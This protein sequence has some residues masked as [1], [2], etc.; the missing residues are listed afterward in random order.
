MKAQILLAAFLASFLGGMYMGYHLHSSFT[1]RKEVSIVNDKIEDDNEDK[2]AITE[3]V[4]EVEK[5]VYV[6]RDKIIYLPA[7]TVDDSGCGLN[8]SVGLRQSVY[9]EFPEVL[10]Q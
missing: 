10:F 6:T 8:S 4:T 3:H 5:V 9:N 1:L 2:K 7:I